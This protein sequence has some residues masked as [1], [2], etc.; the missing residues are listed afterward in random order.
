MWQEGKGMRGELTEKF[1]FQSLSTSN[2]CWVDFEE[3]SL[4]EELLK[5]FNFYT[6]ISDRIKY[7][8]IYRLEEVIAG[9]QP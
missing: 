2:G 3:S 8:V 7:R 1:I 4:K 6:E 5:K 9:P